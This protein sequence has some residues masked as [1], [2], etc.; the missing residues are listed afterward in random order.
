MAIGNTSALTVGLVQGGIRMLGTYTTTVA[1]SYLAALDFRTGQMDWASANASWSSAGTIAGALGAGVTT[2]LNTILPSGLTTTQQQNWGGVLGFGAGMGG[3]LMRFGVHTAYNLGAGHGLD[4]F[5]RA[6]DDMGG[7]TLNLMNAGVLAG[8]FGAD[9]QIANNL[10]VGL[11]E[12]N[13]SRHGLNSRFGTGGIDVSRALYDIGNWGVSEISRRM[14]VPEGHLLFAVHKET[15]D[16]SL[17]AEV[18]TYDR[19]NQR[20]AALLEAGFEE[21]TLDPDW[22]EN[23][24]APGPFQTIYEAARHF[25]KEWN[26]ISIWNNEEWATTIIKTDGGLTYMLPRTDNLP[27]FVYFPIP[28][29]GLGDVVGGVHTHGGWDPGFNSNIFSSHDKDEARRF[30]LPI[31]V[32]TPNGSLLIYDPSVGIPREVSLDM[33]LPFDPTD[34]TSPNN[35]IR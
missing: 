31:F 1:T 5:G 25:G 3:E 15:S 27:D 20:R 11:F 23:W 33:P 4:S 30:G 8:M 28:L 17:D 12:L 7:L 21:V 10:N 22:E 29:D 26:P 19:E 6:F 24:R 14:A 34:P 16:R 35:R 2:G 18:T 13:I 32:S 9:A